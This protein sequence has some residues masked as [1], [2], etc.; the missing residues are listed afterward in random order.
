MINPKTLNID[1]F[2]VI[3]SVLNVSVNTAI[4]NEYIK[5]LDENFDEE[6][7]FDKFRA[8]ILHDIG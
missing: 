5:K 2:K 7:N 6:L 8:L 4:L 1:Q 3:L